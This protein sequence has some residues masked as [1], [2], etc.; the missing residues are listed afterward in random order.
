MRGGVE[1]SKWEIVINTVG[2]GRKISGGRRDNLDCGTIGQSRSF[3]YVQYVV[4]WE[5]MT[6]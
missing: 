1:G 6:Y 2:G 3:H 4:F 5:G